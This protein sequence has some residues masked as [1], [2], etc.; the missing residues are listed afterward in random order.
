MNIHEMIWTVVTDCSE[1]FLNTA[2]ETL[3][4]ITVKTNIDT[5]DTI[6]SVKVR[7]RITFAT[8]S[9]LSTITKTAEI[10]TMET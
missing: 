4:V 10:V 9:G 5:C 3:N 8:G 7:T 6:T 2:I 1:F